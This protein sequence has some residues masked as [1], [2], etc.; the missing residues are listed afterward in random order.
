MNK[1]VG[2]DLAKEKFDVNYIDRAGKEIQKVVKNNL[3]AITS[4]LNK[5]SEGYTLVAE[6]TGVYGDLLLFSCTVRNIPISYCSGYVI[7]HSMGLIKEKTDQVDAARIKEYG[8]RFTD[9]LKLT[10]FD[11]EMMYEL[12]SL[13]A[14]RTQL[15][16]TKQRL[17]SYETNRKSRPF[18]S[19]SVQKRTKVTII[20]LELEINEIEAEMEYLIKKNPEMQENYEII[21]SI[22]GVG[23][24][25]A[26][27]LI[28]KT[29]NF[30]RID[31]ARKLASYAG[32]CPFANESGA[33][34]NKKRISKFRDTKLK[35]YLYMGVK[36]ALPHNKDFKHYYAL[37]VAEKKHHFLIMNNLANKLVRTIYSCVEN[38][39]FYSRDHICLDPRIN[40]A[41][42]V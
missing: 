20:A 2:I 29:G 35:S 17:T 4:F 30:K 8:E 5:V 19:I 22:Q 38:K 11:T 14:L 31:T 39:R 28:V 13:H 42:A 27:D 37:K 3:K 7:K 34:V 9:K 32:I 36:S 12:E 16:K 15:A 41:N 23:P 6:H 24:V 1:I 26:V 25:I 10:E 21:R 33:M 40:T 18:Q